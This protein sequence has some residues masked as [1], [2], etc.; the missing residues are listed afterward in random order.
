MNENTKLNPYEHNTEIIKAFFKKPV[1]LLASVFTFADLIFKLVKSIIGPDKFSAQPIVSKLFPYF[2]DNAQDLDV[3]GGFSLDILGLLLALSLLLFFICARNPRSRLKTPTVMF[4]V[5]SVIEFIIGCLCAVLILILIAV[6]GITGGGIPVFALVAIPLLMVIL[7]Y[8]ILSVLSLLMF[9]RSID[10]SINSIYLYDN[11]AKIFGVL[12][13]IN[14]ALSLASAVF[15]DAAVISN[16][17]L[18]EQFSANIP[19]LTASAVTGFLSSVF[20]GIT[21][22]KY[23]SY[24][25]SF[26]RDFATEAPLAED[27]SEFEPHP[28]PGAADVTPPQA[29]MPQPQQ[30]QVTQPLPVQ[31][32]PKPQPEPQA[33]VCQS[34]GNRVSPEDYFCNNCGAKILK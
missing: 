22:L 21:A 15:L 20:V 33:L 16:A 10:K 14:A 25:K 29:Y 19:I 24:I 5:F 4:R 8:L 28:Y 1:V 9:A 6:I 11:G 12:T 30:Q 31:E 13:V 27:Y 2:E 26:T 34:C 32:T 18:Y 3:S 23:S 7:A 17:S